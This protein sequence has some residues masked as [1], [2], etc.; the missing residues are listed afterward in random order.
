MHQ[1]YILRYR[2]SHRE[3][4][5]SRSMQN[6]VGWKKEGEKSR[7]MS[8]N[9]TCT[10]GGGGWRIWEGVRSWHWDN[11]LGQ[12]GSI[13]GYQR[14]KQLIH[15]S[16]NGVRATQI[17][18]TAALHIQD[19]DASPSESAAS[20]SWSIETGAQ[21]QGEDHCWLWE[22]SLRE[23]KEDHN[24]ECSWRKTEQVWRQGIT[25]QSHTRGGTTL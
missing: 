10:W 11:W 23:W 17:I 7:R 22:D 6:S 9:L 14:V 1:E 13:W 16:M 20:G 8:G 5:E 2:S 24:R 4:D 18:C 15:D 25:A 19:W 12:R 21:S 3:P